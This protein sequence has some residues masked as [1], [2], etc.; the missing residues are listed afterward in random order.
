M[1]S[2]NEICVEV[3]TE[4]GQSKTKTVRFRFMTGWPVHLGT[5]KAWM[6]AIVPTRIAFY[7]PRIT[8]YLSWHGLAQLPI[9]ALYR[10]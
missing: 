2:Q 8:W 9:I 5:L 7:S 6:S 1:I 4:I 10:Q 3:R